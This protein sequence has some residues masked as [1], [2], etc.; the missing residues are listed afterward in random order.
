MKKAFCFDYFSMS[1]PESKFFHIWFEFFPS[2]LSRKKEISET[3]LGFLFS[4]SVTWEKLKSDVRYI[5]PLPR[6]AFPREGTGVKTDFFFREKV[7]L[8]A[9]VGKKDGCLTDRSSCLPERSEGRQRREVRQSFRPETK[10]RE[11]F[12]RKRKRSDRTISL[13]GKRFL[14]RGMHFLSWEG[15]SER[16]VGQNYKMAKKLTYLQYALGQCFKWNSS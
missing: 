6:N 12:S 3:F 14:S 5:F 13:P 15:F 8:S 16:L 11:T 4:T 1:R 2:Y 7:S 10:E 9:V